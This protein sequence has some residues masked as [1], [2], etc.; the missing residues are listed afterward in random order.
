MQILAERRK[1]GLF[2][3]LKDASTRLDLCR[4]DWVSLVES[5]CCDSLGRQYRRSEQ[6]RIL[7]TNAERTTRSDQLELFA[8]EKHIPGQTRSLVQVKHTEDELHREFSALGFLRSYHPLLLWSS[9]LQGL[10]RVRASEL[11]QYVGRYVNLIGYQITQKQVMTKTGES[12]SFVSF[13]DE[14]AL[15][16]TVLFPDL[17]QRFYPLLS[18]LWPLVVFGLVQDDQGALIVE[19]Q[20][21][22]KVGS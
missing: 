9:Y 17:Y 11:S 13:E 3:D 2:F 8:P 22:K 18:S 12:M 10:K 7:L 15:Y 14:T 16:E 1:G 19:V 5:G 6:L 20:H 21:L 4:E